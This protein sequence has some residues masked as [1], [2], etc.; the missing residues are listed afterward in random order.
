MR[1]RLAATVLAVTAMVTIAF[2]VPLGAVVR[3]VAADRAVSAADQESRSLATLLGAVD[4][5]GAITT[6]L[7]QLNAGSPRSAAVFLPDGTRLGAPL[8]VPNA[9][10]ELAR[11]GR[12]FTASGA[13]GR[14]VW[15]P[16]RQANGKTSAGV[17]F[18]PQGLLTKGVYKAWIVLGSVGLLMVLIGV[19]LADRLAHSMVVSMEELREV[20]ERL[21]QG[22]LDARVEPRGPVEVV[23]VGNSV[24]E[25]ARRIG[26]LLVG[27]REAAADLS[28]R[29]RTPLTALQLEA[30]GLRDP[31]ERDRM[32]SAVNDLTNAVT[33]VIRQ[34]REPRPQRKGVPV[35]DLLRIIRTRLEF[36]SVLAEDQRRAW[37]LDALPGTVAVGVAPDELAAVVDALL[38]NVFAHTAEGTAFRVA[39]VPRNGGGGVLVVEDRGPGFNAPSPEVR[40]KSGAGST[41]LGLDIVRRTA[42]ASGGS[43]RLGRP[44]EGGAAVVVEFGPPRDDAEAR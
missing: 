13:G 23:E 31:A 29:L 32:G 33:A 21:H 1:A 36:W 35:S 37:H 18:V 25:L 10:L 11:Q 6:V 20:T 4:T 3:V 27:E 7:A 17:V 14:R 24:N 22:D 40:G 5:P 44:T 12:A 38:A 26:E 19:G 8:A 41:G 42:E 16:V 9:E 43:M 34:A 15:V 28:H 30:E 39:V 2:L